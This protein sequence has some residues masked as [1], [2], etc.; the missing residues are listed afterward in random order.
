MRND[1]L[2]RR[3]PA[4]LL[5]LA[6]CIHAQT[7]DN[8]GSESTSLSLP[9]RLWVSGQANLITQFN[10]AFPAK[11]SGPNSFG[12]AAE[13][14]TSRV[15]TLYTGLRLT[16]NTEVLFDLESAGGAGLSSAL[17]IAGF[18]NL[19][20]VRN[21][22]LGST[23]YV[24]RVMLHQ[25]IPLSS[26]YDD[27]VRGP[28]GLAS[29]L[30]VRRIELR[31]GKLSTV[32][33]FDLNGIGTDS[34]LQFMNW[35]ADNNAAFDYAA[36]TRG[37]TYGFLAEFYDPN[38][39]VR[40]GEML[41]PKVA[42]GLELDW[43]I[44]RARGQNFELE[45]HPSPFRNHAS[46][47][48]LL[49]FTNS[50]NMGSYREAI[51]AYRNGQ[52]QTPDIT[53]TRQQGRLKYGFGINLEQTLGEGWRAYGRFGWNDG[54]N[55]S[56]AYTE[57]DQ[58]ISFGSDLRGLKWRRPEDKLGTA[59]LLDAISE[60]HRTYLALGGLGF[61]LG[62][63]ALNYGREKIWET[64]YNLHVWRGVYVGGDV[65]RVW[66][67]GY[68][69]DRGPVSVFSIRLHVEDAANFGNSH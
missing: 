59:I 62:D 20:V 9:E 17:G 3:V 18:T 48:R 21:P 28:L 34:H 51:Q 38:F 33:F 12:P 35:A 63:G 60:D 4:L 19:D 15:L 36:D 30:P 57:V 22:T 43:N 41:M 44:A 39:V 14:A 55:E 31:F 47:V 52:A 6:A 7:I 5:C 26:Q 16:H 64:Y 27:A 61:I 10:P 13:H 2:T 40:F 56:F 54:K 25:V 11:Y 66:N 49:A 32:D 23:P 68:N 1:S 65:Q 29:K 46:T 69:R 42:N 67:P 53:A 45:L 24:G 37:Y 8:S 50:A 58:S